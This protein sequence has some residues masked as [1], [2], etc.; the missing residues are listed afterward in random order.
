M[1]GVSRRRYAKMW[2][3]DESA[4]RKAIRA[5]QVRLHPDGSVDVETSDEIWGRMHL[6]R[7][8]PTPMDPEVAARVDATLAEL[9]PWLQAAWAECFADREGSPT[10]D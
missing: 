7:N 8:T 6:L 10:G 1:Q 4:I 9:Q 5:G 3:V 2:D